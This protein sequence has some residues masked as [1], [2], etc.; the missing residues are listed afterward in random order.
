MPR[1]Y[2][3]Q[4]GRAHKT[5]TKHVHS[6]ETENAS[7]RGGDRP[8]NTKT[9]TSSINSDNTA[10]PKKIMLDELRVELLMELLEAILGKTIEDIS[11][12]FG[13]SVRSSLDLNANTPL[14][15]STIEGID[16]DSALAESRDAVASSILTG[17][18]CRELMACQHRVVLWSAL[19][20]VMSY[21]LPM[22]TPFQMHR[23]LSNS[24][25]NSN[26]GSAS[27][28]PNERQQAI[29][30]M[31]I[32]MQL[33]DP[34]RCFLAALAV[35][36]DVSC[37]CS[38]RLAKNAVDML[39]PALFPSVFLSISPLPSSLS[40]SDCVASSRSLFAQLHEASGVCL[41]MLQDEFIGRNQRFLETLGEGRG[42]GVYVSPLDDSPNALKV[43][44]G[45]Y[46]KP[47][48]SSSGSN[49]G[50]L[51]EDSDGGEPGQSTAIAAAAAAAAAAAGGN[52]NPPGGNNN[53]QT[54]AA[55]AGIG[56]GDSRHLRERIVPLEFPLGADAKTGPSPA[57]SYSSS[58]SSSSSSTAQAKEK[59][60]SPRVSIDGVTSLVRGGARGQ[61]LSLLQLSSTGETLGLG[62]GGGGDVRGS[63]SLDPAHLEYKSSFASSRSSRTAREEARGHLRDSVT[64]LAGSYDASSGSGEGYSVPLGVLR[65]HFRKCVVMHSEPSNPNPNPNPN[66]SRRADGK[67]DG[68]GFPLSM[69]AD[70]HDEDG[71][72]HGHGHGHDVD[73][74]FP[75]S[76]RA[77]KSSLVR[78]LRWSVGA[79]ELAVRVLNYRSSGNRLRDSISWG[80]VLSLAQQHPSSSSPCSAGRNGSG[81]GS[82]VTSPVPAGF[83]DISVAAED[84]GGVDGASGV[85]QRQRVLASYSSEGLDALIGL[86]PP[87]DDLP[88]RGELGVIATPPS[89]LLEGAL[90]RAE[91]PTLRG[92]RAAAREAA[93][94]EPLAPAA[95]AAAAYKTL[96][97][98]PVFTYISGA[99]SVTT[100]SVT[101][102]IM[103]NISAHEASLV[104]A[105]VKE[106]Q[107]EEGRTNTIG[108]SNGTGGSSS[109]QGKAPAAHQTQEMKPLPESPSNGDLSGL[110]LSS[111]DQD[112]DEE[113]EEE[114]EEEDSGA[115]GRGGGMQGRGREAR[116][117][118]LRGLSRGSGSNSN[119]RSRSR[120]RG[121]A[122]GN[123]GDSTGSASPGSRAGAGAGAA[124]GRGEGGGGERDSPDRRYPHSTQQH[125]LRVSRSGS[126]VLHHVPASTYVFCHTIVLPFFSCLF[127]MSLPLSLSLSYPS[128]APCLHSMTRHDV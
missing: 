109:S 113:E 62:G 82:G 112:E 106:A 78:Y 56:A 10:L 34:Y 38:G 123:V 103:S 63:I 111:D 6:A 22:I 80:S 59:A 14:T 74:D 28:L 13:G 61:G 58:S 37:F 5:P 8:T 35:V 2:Q 9:Y 29:T 51:L 121:R 86:A 42:R 102:A 55:A 1:S 60:E 73:H 115:R 85:Q 18:S 33:D 114:E 44:L 4:A 122:L 65:S 87:M 43:A 88:P 84:G 40:P 54:A 104:S 36:V 39:G 53:P 24:N 32:I 30:A 67:H 16:A 46:A 94:S 3:Q 105:E 26:S 75:L 76:T 50:E 48:D 27:S 79:P 91:S 77:D 107:E 101:S 71:E 52:Y 120:S 117:S 126:L 69:R 45:L 90:E 83:L 41:C 95:A 116:S 19:I 64:S 97:G 92:L 118:R 127:M 119:S 93:V 96:P 108:S 23:L 21:R 72:G 124:G 7:N 89:L 57:A 81:N 66:P 12:G 17:V 11:A 70:K 31:K 99:H 110:D 47:N 25:S 15:M 20:K 68:D 125:K 98:E 49:A 100:S 128:I